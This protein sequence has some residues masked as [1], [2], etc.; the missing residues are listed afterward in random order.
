MLLSQ[1]LGLNLSQPMLDFVDIDL[2]LD[3]PL[4]IDP[5]GFLKPRDQFAQRCQDDLRSFF[6]AVLKAIKK[7]DQSKGLRLLEGLRE[8]NETHLGVSKGKPKGRGLGPEQAQEVLT[9]LMNSKAAKTGLLK[10]LTDTALFIPGIGA[11]KVSDMTTNIIRRHL[12]AYTQEQFELLKQQ[13]PGKIPTGLLWDPA[14]EDWITD[15]HDHIPVINGERVLLVPKRYVRWRGGLHQAA[16]KYYN[17]FVTNYIKDEQ[18]ATNGKLV[19]VVK[20][21]KRTRRVVTK[22][23]IKKEFPLSKRFLEEFSAKHPAEYKKFRRSLDRH[24][25]LGM[26]KLVEANGTQF[27]ETAFSAGLV[28]ALAKIPTGR[29]H[30]NDYHHLITGI[31]TYLFYPDLIS[32]ALELEINDGRKRIDLSFQNS[33]E[34]GFFK[35]R[36]DDKFAQSREV[37]IECKNY[38]DDI[39]NPEIDQMAGRFDPRRGRFGM[40]TCRAIDKPDALARR[41]ADVFRAQNGI[42]LCLTDAEI[43]TLLALAPLNRDQAIQVMLRAK[44]REIS[45]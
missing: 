43:S 18:L 42:I 5:A 24:G 35:D 1:A 16:S 4:Y 40:V 33:A 20:T 37:I 15:E 31:L 8:P 17:N 23:R 25:P 36:K 13:I 38:G 10:D 29:R 44:L 27:N 32:P 19:E 41:L 22:Q 30:A 7:G 34:T 28:A 6:G 45:K 9:A 3:F 12:I 11:D 39:A 14:T 21:K 2:D 26:R